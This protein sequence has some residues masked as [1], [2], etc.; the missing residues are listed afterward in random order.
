MHFVNY[1]IVIPDEQMKPMISG[2]YIVQIFERDNPDEV[3]AEARFSV[4]EQS[5]SI[6]GSVSPRTDRGINTEWQQMDLAVTATDVAI[7]DPYTMLRVDITQNNAPYTT[8]TLRTPSRI[9]GKN[10]IYTHLPELIFKAGNEFRRFET[11]RTNYNDMNV[12]SMR[13]LSNNYHAWLTPDHE[14]DSRQYTY[15]QTQQGRFLIREYNSTDSDL[16]ADYVT[17][18]FRLDAPEVIDA[19]VYVEGEFTEFKHNESNRMR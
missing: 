8:S 13:F 14:R 3:L 18:H 11:V 16:G 10:I 7:A 4:T 9:D 1:R 15:D 19:D 2:N 5:A 6:N 12:D 17:V